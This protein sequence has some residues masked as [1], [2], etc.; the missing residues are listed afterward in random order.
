MEYDQIKFPQ[1]DVPGIL[2]DLMYYLCR[3]MIEEKETT[4]KFSNQVD[5]GKTKS[6][7]GFEFNERA[8]S[9]GSA[10]SKDSGK[11]KKSNFKSS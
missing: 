3:V 1:A 8:S 5:I 6:K 2:R 11:S 7:V 10:R 4:V 9:R